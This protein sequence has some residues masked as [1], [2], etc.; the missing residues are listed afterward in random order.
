[1]VPCLVSTTGSK[2]DVA[3][4]ERPQL[5]AATVYAP[6]LLFNILYN[7]EVLRNLKISGVGVCMDRCIVHKNAIYV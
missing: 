6:T 2:A 5:R 1:M 7:G 3:E 4:N